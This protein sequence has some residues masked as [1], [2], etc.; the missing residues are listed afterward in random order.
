MAK[1]IDATVNFDELISNGVVVVDFWA[2]WCGPCKMLEPV[3]EEVVEQLPNVVFAKANCDKAPELA[4][5]YH[6]ANI[7]ALLI[8][9]NGKEVDRIVGLSDEEEIVEAI[10]SHL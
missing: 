10:N 2:P 5:Q 1:Y 9:K 6:V 7:P 3:L 4:K 8:F